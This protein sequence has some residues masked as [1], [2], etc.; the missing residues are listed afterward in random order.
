[1][2]TPKN[3]Q[4]PALTGARAKQRDTVL[5]KDTRNRAKVGCPCGHLDRHEC[6]TQ[7]PP[8]LMKKCSNECM[9]WGLERLHYYAREL[10]HCP[11]VD[12]ELQ[13]IQAAS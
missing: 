5:H 12:D 4:T 3:S 7:T 6:V 13:P 9:N 11:C 2:S 1:M 8:P 10:G